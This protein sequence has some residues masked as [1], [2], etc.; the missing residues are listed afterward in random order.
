MDQRLVDD[1]ITPS[2]DALRFKAVAWTVF[3]ILRSSSYP[4]KPFWSVSINII[5]SMVSE[6]SQ[7]VSMHTDQCMNCASLAIRA[8]SQHYIQKIS[9]SE[10]KR[11]S[12]I[13]TQ[14][15]LSSVIS[16]EE[17]LFFTHKVI[18]DRWWE[19]LLHDPLC[20]LNQTGQ[21][22][23][24]PFTVDAADWKMQLVMRN[25][26][27]SLAWCLLQYA[28]CDVALSPATIITT[29]ALLTVPSLIVYTKT[30]DF[31]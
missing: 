3:P 2:C 4:C 16:V 14:H 27:S 31:H 8:N 13:Q 7:R 9:W 23:A 5:M 30:L 18:M 25:H 12:N 26:L 21:I 19:W 17:C 24:R 22:F 6:L 20:I 11:R 1:I 15:T 28:K 29:Y 10:V